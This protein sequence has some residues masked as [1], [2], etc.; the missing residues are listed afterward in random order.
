[1]SR[2]GIFWL[3]S[4]PKSGNTWVRCLIA[5]LQHGAAEVDLDE[6]A[7]ALPN[8]ASRVWLARHLDVDIGELT[9]TELHL[10]R[11]AAYRRCAAQTLSILKVH[12]HHDPMLFPAAATLGTVYIVRDPRD[13]AH[14]WAD[15]ACLDLDTAIEQL[16]KSGTTMSASMAEYRPQALQRYGSWSEHVASWQQAPGPR[17]LLR[18]ED[19]Q[20]DP[21]R[22]TARLA[23]FLG[24]PAEPTQ[25]ARAVAACGF[26][27]LRDTEQ[28]LGFAERQK[29]QARFFRQGRA[30]AWRSALNATQ[31]ARVL[32]DHGPIMAWLGYRDATPLAKRS[33]GKA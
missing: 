32:A 1:M 30:G 7:P 3:A 23:D 29:G 33:F 14:S 27:T 15:H 31:A 12:D 9:P 18:Y 21:L 19:L 10:L 26:E 2:R 4:Y 16:G 11:G 24:L 13:V 28:R 25:V 22:E 5:S 6:L 20:A 17:L 8:A